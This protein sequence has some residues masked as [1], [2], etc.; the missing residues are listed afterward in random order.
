[1]PKPFGKPVM[2]RLALTR[3]MR[4]SIALLVAALPA[5]FIGHFAASGYPT[6]ASR[7][8]FGTA[9]LVLA[10]FYAS[11]TALWLRRRPSP[12]APG[13]SSRFGLFVARF[14]LT[15]LLALPAG[16]LSAFFY[17]PALTLANGMI[18]PGGSETEPAMALV[19]P[20]GDVELRLLYREPAATWTVPTS[21]LRPRETATWMTARLTLRRGCLGAQ[22]VEK[23]DYEV[24]K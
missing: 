19:R 4:L 20:N 13:T 14:F 6:I 15:M 2:H 7:P 23:V 12:R 3:G 16:L 17:G 22:W 9:A 8:F 5:Y 21:R 24:L 11:T 18:S 10:V 1:M